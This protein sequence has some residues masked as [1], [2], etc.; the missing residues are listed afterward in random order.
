MSEHSMVK[1]GLLDFPLKYELEHLA[2]VLPYSHRYHKL[3]LDSLININP[4]FPILVS[5]AIIIISNYGIEYRLKMV[6]IGNFRV[7]G[8]S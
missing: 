2:Y 1:I 4:N 7:E 8:I 3:D 5:K 6:I